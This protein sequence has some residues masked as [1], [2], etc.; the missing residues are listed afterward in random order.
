MTTLA[1]F[2]PCN[3]RPVGSLFLFFFFSPST[4]VSGW[5]S[6]S[7]H[8]GRRCPSICSKI[9]TTVI[10]TFLRA[11]P[12]IWHFN[13]PT[14]EESGWRARNV[15]SCPNEN[16]NNHVER[17]RDGEP[18]RGEEKGEGALRTRLHSYS[19]FYFRSFFFNFSFCHFCLPR[20]TQL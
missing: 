19:I 1:L 14:L 3:C 4:V 6:Y 17:H 13:A 2:D 7:R 10:G 18:K 15:P 9:K 5:N 16:K 8:R 11:G 20:D 12:L